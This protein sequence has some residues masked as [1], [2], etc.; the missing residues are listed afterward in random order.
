MDEGASRHGRRYWGRLGHDG[1]GGVEGRDLI[2]HGRGEP[3]GK[4][5]GET[6]WA[7]DGT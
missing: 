4:G 3:Q 6:L 7:S 1:A 5:V 2:R